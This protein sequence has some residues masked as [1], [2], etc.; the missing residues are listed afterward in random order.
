MG[1]VYTS[2]VLV[3][4][5]ADDDAHELPKP[6]WFFVDVVTTAMLRMPDVERGEGEDRYAEDKDREA[7][8][9]KMRAVL[10][11]CKSKGAGRLVLG[12]WGCG[13]YANPVGEVARAWKRVLLG[14]AKK[15]GEAWDGLEVVFAIRD[16]KMAK[17]FATRFGDGLEVVEVAGAEPRKA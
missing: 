14:T 6:D 5:S 4:G 17:E 13:A 3:F 10:R 12:A 16:T 11:M 8:V 7:A 1:G 15:P 2:D 9:D